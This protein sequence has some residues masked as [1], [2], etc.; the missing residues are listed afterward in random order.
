LPLTIA[1]QTHRRSTSLNPSDVDDSTR[2]IQANSLRDGSGTAGRV[3]LPRSHPRTDPWPNRCG[4][5]RPRAAGDVSDTTARHPIT[6][7][8]PRHPATHDILV[9]APCTGSQHGSVLSRAGE[10]DR[11]RGALPH[12]PARH[13][14]LVHSV[15]KRAL[16][17][18][19]QTG[20]FVHKRSF[21]S[22]KRLVHSVVKG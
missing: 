14:R 18:T 17:C 15:T 11:Q 1:F 2:L 13:E 22:R 3:P 12:S 6:H 4:G 10:S 16:F 9:P 20:V 7:Q 21:S 8:H 19:A 5:R